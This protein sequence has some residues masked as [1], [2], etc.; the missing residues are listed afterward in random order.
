MLKTHDG[1]LCMKS[2][3]FNYNLNK[4][5]RSIHRLHVFALHFNYECYDLEILTGDKRSICLQAIKKSLRI[6]IGR[7]SCRERV[8]L[9]IVVG[10]CTIY[11]S[12][13]CERLYLILYSEVKCE[14][15]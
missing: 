14:Y 11:K 7:S 12:F 15:R 1:V 6:K 3:N 5:D 4:H 8:E 13:N 2:S 10:N 9:S